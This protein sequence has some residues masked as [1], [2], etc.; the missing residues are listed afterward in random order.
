MFRAKDEMITGCPLKHKFVIPNIQV[1]SNDREV[2]RVFFPGVPEFPRRGPELAIVIR[3][4]T[5]TSVSR[6]EL[7]WPSVL[8]HHFAIDTQLLFFLV[9]LF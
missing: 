4:H 7:D 5:M 8:L 6:C 9:F 2:R 3:D 1:L